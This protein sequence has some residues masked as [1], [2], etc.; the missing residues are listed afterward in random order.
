[1]LNDPQ[2]ASDDLMRTITENCRT[3]KFREQ[4]FEES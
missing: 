1:V 4:G 3:L 2:G